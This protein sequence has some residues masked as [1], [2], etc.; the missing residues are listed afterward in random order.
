M[1]KIL[2]VE[3]SKMFGEIVTQKLEQT[4][5][6]TVV[7]TQSLK[8]TKNLLEKK[9]DSFF[10]ALLDLN[11]PDA[12]NGEIIDIVVDKKIPSIVFTSSVSTEIRD[13][14]WSKKVVDYI[15]KNDPSS[16]D[17]ITALIKK[18]DNNGNIKILVVDDSKFFINI[19]SNLL[20]VHNFEVLNANNGKDALEVVNS[21]T[22]IRLVITDYNMPEM[23]GY[24]LCRELRQSFSKEK[25]GIVGMSSAEDK[26]TGAGFLKAGANDFIVKQ[27]FLV[28]EFYARIYNC[29]EHIDLFCKVREAAIK[30]YMTGLFNRRY[31]FEAG[32]S[33][34]ENAKRKHLTLTCAMVD[35]D[36]F[37]KVNDT[38]GHD[39]GDEVIKKIAAILQSRMRKTD[40]VA[41]FGGEEFC[42]L[43]TNMDKR[44]TYNI[45][46]NIRKIVEA[47]HIFKNDTQIQVTV[48]IGVCTRQVNSLEEMIILSDEQL[49]ISK[50]T[51]RNKVSV[52]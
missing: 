27:S 2:F 33:L 41:R 37:K 10:C 50:T 45:F 25:L 39:T 7:L 16:I 3:D 8:E 35:I 15:I 24:S 23:D 1:K 49:Y 21:N 31:F 12:P 40:I 51:G 34:F 22:D 36:F 47:S 28:E 9:S 38:Y 52:V 13:F 14:V 6:I 4:L 5:G 29:L 43:A 20:K 42:I 18:L 17:Y 32:Q 19:L 30:D 11:L 44:Q 26:N 48:S 46:E